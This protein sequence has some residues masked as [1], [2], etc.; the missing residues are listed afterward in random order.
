[1][2]IALASLTA[3]ALVLI[4]VGTLAQSA[5]K[6]VSMLSDSLTQREATS[7]EINRTQ[8]QVVKT[9]TDTPAMVDIT[10]KNIGQVPLLEFAS[11][12][13]IIE[14]YEADD[15]YHQLW[16]SYTTSSSPGDNQ[17]TVTGL[18]LDASAG[19]PEVFQPN[20]LDPEEELIIRAKLA[21][22]AGGSTGNRVVISS[23]NGVSASS[24]F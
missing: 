14:Y 24:P 2:S 23:P 16:L 6:S 12:D 20:I 10:V 9:A 17:W 13:V 15:T 5:I 3:I 4:T 7:S 18:Y 19:D 1:M 21:P 8:I 22:A 11:W